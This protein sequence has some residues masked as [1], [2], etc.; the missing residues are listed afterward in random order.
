MVLTCVL[1]WGRLA[2]GVVKT[3]GGCGLWL[4]G[5]DIAVGFLGVYI[6]LIECAVFVN[7]VVLWAGHLVESRLGGRSLLNFAFSYPTLGL[8]P[9]GD[10]LC[11]GMPWRMGMRVF[12]MMCGVRVN[13]ALE[14]G[15][16]GCVWVMRVEPLSW[17]P[18]QLQVRPA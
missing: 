16:D 2:M 13:S 12:G 7:D 1:S 5:S 8:V 6:C 17:E 18:L 11:F 4:C 9:L 15:S 14:S 10:V 3:N